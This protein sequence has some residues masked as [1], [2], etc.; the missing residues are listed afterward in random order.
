[1]SLQYYKLVTHILH[2]WHFLYFIPSIL[3]TNCMIFVSSWSQTP[4]LSLCMN[5][6][7]TKNELKSLYNLI[8]KKE[9]IGITLAHVKSPYTHVYIQKRISHNFLLSMYLWLKCRVAF[10]PRTSVF[11]LKYSLREVTFLASPYLL[12]LVSKC[13]IANLNH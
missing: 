4:N 13:L 11:Q 12:K 5:L 6:V 2:V 9:F 7:F 3:L 1:M 8:K 10:I